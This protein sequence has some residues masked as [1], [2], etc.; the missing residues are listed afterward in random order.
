MAGKGLKKIGTDVAVPDK[1]FRGYYSGTKEKIEK[2]GLRYVNY[3]HFGNSHMHLNFLPSNQEEYIKARNLYKEI[4]IDAI[5]LK[6][7]FSAEHGVGKSKREYLLEMYGEDS[8]KKMAALKKVFDPNSILNIGNIFD[9]KYL[10]E[11]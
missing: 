5:R 2:S 8:V 6:G 1:Y 11:L 4:C 9:E 10:K 7:T 3:G